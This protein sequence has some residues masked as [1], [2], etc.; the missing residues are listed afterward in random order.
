MDKA[1]SV[2]PTLPTV[3]VKVKKKHTF[4]LS[5]GGNLPLVLVIMVTA[6]MGMRQELE[7]NFPNGTLYHSPYSI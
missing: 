3:F 4:L 2:R 5:P 1:L 6:V 7:G